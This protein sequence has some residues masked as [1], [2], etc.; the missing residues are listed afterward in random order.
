MTQVNNI[1]SIWGRS[2][3]LTT[4]PFDTL[5]SKHVKTSSI[6]ALNGGFEKG[7]SMLIDSIIKAV[8][9]YID[10]LSDTNKSK[11]GAI[12]S[13]GD[14]VYIERSSKDLNIIQLLIYNKES[15]K[16]KACNYNISEYESY[17]YQLKGLRKPSGSIGTAIFLALMPLVLEDNEAIDIFQKYKLHL[18]NTSEIDDALL[19]LMATLCDN[20][21]Q[22]VVSGAIK[23]DISDN[24][25]LKKIATQA[26][27]IKKAAPSNVILGEFKIFDIKTSKK[28]DREKVI[29]INPNEYRLNL[30]RELTK[31]EENHIIKIPKSHSVTPEELRICKEVKRNWSKDDM[32][33]VNI[34]LEGDAGS[35][36]T[37]LA[38]ALSYD[39]GLP[40]TKITCFADMDKSD[41]IGSILPV[42]SNDEIKTLSE[43]DANLLRLVYNLQDNESVYDTL[44]K[45]MG[46]SKG[47]IKVKTKWKH[48]QKLSKEK[49]GDNSV[50]YK[51][52]PS[53]IVRAFKYGYLLEI[54]EPTVI[55]DAAVLMSLNSA[56]EV[57]GSI[58]L[59]TEV[60]SRHSDFVAVITTNRNYVGCRPLNEALRDRVQHCEKMDLPSKEVIVQRAMAKTGCDDLELTSKLAD[61]II[62]LDETAK[63]N[64]IRGVAGMR[65]L[66]YWLDAVQNGDS[67]RESMYHK[68]IYKM[69]TD[70][71]EIV[72]LEDAVENNT[73]L[74]IET[75]RRR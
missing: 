67:V 54:Q 44:A 30:S 3:K 75:R 14:D 27:S 7:Q 33:I 73:S 70:P 38:K 69:T 20:I 40:Y 52:F 74:F 34:L 9:E 22:R 53:E 2:L 60:V 57:D 31:E 48:L 41:V 63:A 65:S 24:M 6:Y 1:S 55:R 25:P 39:L 37:Q 21:Y 51:F 18:E 36:K 64:A 26:I 50:E 4:K 35:G 10:L 61:A 45:G 5:S 72:L 11:F 28:I 49:S 46:L 71:D 23:L 59:P 13:N 16:C 62:V 8:H 42:I 68:V 43:E 58:N 47:D 12:G 29:T 66:F 17:A 56:L 32:K 19:K 15:G